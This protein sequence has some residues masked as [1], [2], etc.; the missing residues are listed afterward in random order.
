MTAPPAIF[1]RAAR[2]L[3]RDRYARQGSDELERHVVEI[4][5]ERLDAVTL[6]FATA[7]VVNTGKGTLAAALG[8]RGIT[9][10]EVD[11]GPVCAATASALLTDEDHLFVEA[12]TYDLV[13]VPAGLDTVDDVPGALIAV[14][15][16]LRP[17]G[18]FIAVLPGAPMLTTL[19]AVLGEA[20]SSNT[21][22]VARL[23]P[24]IDVRA[25]GDLLTRAGFEGPVADV[26]TNT[27]SY[28][29]LDRLIADIRAAGLSNVLAD[30]YPMSRSMLVRARAAFI[31]SAEADGRVREKISLVTMT[32][33]AP[34]AR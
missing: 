5:V 1:D 31:A 13:V 2:R 28:A 33:W 21:A 18:L 32:G 17:G 26:E 4:V 14:R 11:H 7:L 10:D 8:T 23:H 16:A 3:R 9:V 34:A 25:A 24:L 6:S 30:R 22:A 29:T 20:T 27:L 15:R 12:G 19:R